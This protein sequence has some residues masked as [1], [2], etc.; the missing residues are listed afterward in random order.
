MYGV[1]SPSHGPP[2]CGS[3]FAA[4]FGDRHLGIQGG[5][6]QQAGPS[7]IEWGPVHRGLGI[8][9]LGQNQSVDPLSH[10][11]LIVHTLP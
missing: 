6:T 1:E 8:T 11:A 2:F 3:S 9:D 7:G 4:F 5:Q 10:L